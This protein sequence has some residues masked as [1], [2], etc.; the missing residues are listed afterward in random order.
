MPSLVRALLLLILP[1]TLSGC[2]TSDD[3]LISLFDSFTPVRA[4]LYNGYSDGE[5]SN[6]LTV[7]LEGPITRITYLNSDG[8][9][10]SHTERVLMG[11]VQGDY[12]V[13]MSYSKKFQYIYSLIL[14]SS[15]EVTRYMEP[16]NCD[17]L[18][19]EMKED[20]EDSYQDMEDKYSGVVKV[21]R[22]EDINACVFTNYDDVVEAFRRLIKS[23]HLKP[24]IVYVRQSS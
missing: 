15:T 6:S 1:L 12:F 21:R 2:F 4:G 19:D 24:A 16:N 3:A 10:S 8:T 11:R 18:D 17:D 13:V 23:N 14:I 22:V 20:T 7:G 9:E 5:L